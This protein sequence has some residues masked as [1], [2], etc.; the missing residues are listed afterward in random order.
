MRNRPLSRA[1]F[2]LVELMVALLFTM[3]L[4]AGMASVFKASLS[5]FYTSGEK[6]SSMRRNRLAMD[7][8][9]DDLNMAGQYLT[10][11]AAPSGIVD[12]SNPGFIVNPKVAFTGTDIPTA[13]A[14]SDEL[15]FYFDDP[16][17]ME[18]WFGSN[19]TGTASSVASGTAVMLGGTFDLGFKT[20]DEAAKVKSGMMLITR[21]NYEHKKILSAA[22]GSLATTSISIDGVFGEKHLKN[23]GI[24]IAKP[25]Q[26]ARYRIQSRNWDPE[27]PTGVGIPCLIR[28]QGDYPGAGIFAPDD[29]LTTIVAENV[30]RFAVA[31][32]ADRGA[33]WI[34][35][36]SWASIKT[37]L[38]TQLS[39]SGAEFKSIGASSH[40]YRSVPVLVRV[41][42]T[43]RTA[44]ARS[45]FSAAGDALAYKEQTQTLVILPR[46]F[47][48]NF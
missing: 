24:I 36:A 15:L 14:V 43:T 29:S 34:T 9:S 44:T 21:G 20:H 46:H 22:P 37:A 5:A 2:S 31:L 48:L 38:D 7:L 19:M 10:L 30:T 18:G 12:A 35:G 16:L 40:W 25:A 39:A 11:E 4:M 26:Y 3:I 1:G 23:E 42:I 33:T 41:N 17:P 27:K 45:E 8:L 28:E 32:S 6:T 13:D 47:G